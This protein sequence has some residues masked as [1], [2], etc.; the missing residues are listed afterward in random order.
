MGLLK[1]ALKMGEGFSSFHVFIVCIWGE[2]AGMCMQH[3]YFQL[4]S[5]FYCVCMGVSVPGCACG[6]QRTMWSS[7]P[8]F[9]V[10][11]DVSPRLGSEYLCP[12]CHSL[13]F[14]L[15]F[16]IFSVIIIII[17]A[18]VYTYVPQRSWRGQTTALWNQLSSD[19]FTWV[20]GITLRWSLG[21]KCCCL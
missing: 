10:D 6:G 15:C 11:M 1:S 12:E 19:I 9:S 7:C 17:N 16:R 3:C 21:S 8:P 18:C 5:C 13:L 4:F 2:C 20:L 14:Y